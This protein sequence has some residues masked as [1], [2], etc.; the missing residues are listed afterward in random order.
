[1]RDHM[2]MNCFHGGCQGGSSVLKMFIGHLLC[3]SICDKHQ[4]NK[5]LLLSPRS[6]QTGKV[7]DYHRQEDIIARYY[8]RQ[9]E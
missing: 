1:M 4:Q 8:Y 6:L 7:I 5:T 3:D 9:E 2:K